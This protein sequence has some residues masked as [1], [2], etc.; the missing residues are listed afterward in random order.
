M[1][2]RPKTAGVWTRRHV[3]LGHHESVGFE[4]LGER[5]NCW[6]YALRESHFLDLAARHR[7]S[8]SSRVL[9]LGFGNGFYIELYQRL[10]IISVC[11]ADISADAVERAAARFADYRFEVANLAEGLPATLG[12]DFDWVSAMDVLY[13]ITEDDLFAAALRTCGDAVRPGGLL[14]VSDN[15]PQRKAPTKPTQ[16]FHTLRE[17]TSIL[18]PL[19]FTLIE[20][21]PVFFVSNG[22]VG[23]GELSYRLAAAQW[24]ALERVL[25]KAIRVA[26]PA[27]ERLGD[28]LGRLLTGVDRLLQRQPFVQGYSTKVVVFRR[29]A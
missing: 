24:R 10:G 20:T 25:A 27:G 13:H 18:E 7:I 11:G 3:D 21:A 12:A 8:P 9:D 5:Y 2:T 28:G 19:G 14:V 17:Y 6:I 16:A 22:Q 1:P 23:A 29:R 15:F 4:G 26:R